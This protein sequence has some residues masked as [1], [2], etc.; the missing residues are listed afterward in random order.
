MREKTKSTFKG[1]VLTMERDVEDGQWT[2][3]W[4]FDDLVMG[5]NRLHAAGG[6]PLEWHKNLPAIYEDFRPGRL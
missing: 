3:V 5:T 2:D 4:I 1:G 6:M